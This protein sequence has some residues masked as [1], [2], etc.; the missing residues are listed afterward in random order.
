MIDSRLTCPHCGVRTWMRDYTAFMRDHDRPDGRV[1]RIA[2]QSPKRLSQADMF[3]RALRD[4]SEKDQT[5]LEMLYGVNP[6]NDLELATAIERR[7]A[8]WARYAGFIGQRVG[9][10]AIY[11]GA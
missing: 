5:A 7:P 2:Q 6:I 11:W 1:C 8:L 9:S 4:Q 3:Y 10:G